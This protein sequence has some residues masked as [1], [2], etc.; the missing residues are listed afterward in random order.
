ML[1][2]RSE[3]AP[4]DSENSV[5]EMVKFK[6]INSFYLSVN[7]ISITIVCIG[8]G[9]GFLLVSHRT[10]LLHTLPLEIHLGLLIMDP[11][12]LLVNSSDIF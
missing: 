8:W 9:G 10:S 6:K 3:L 2:L 7:F 11:S 12:F 1:E 4:I 5:R